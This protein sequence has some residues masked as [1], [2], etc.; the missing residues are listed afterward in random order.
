MVKIKYLQNR[1]NEVGCVHRTI[2]YFLILT[3]YQQFGFGIHAA[4]HLKYY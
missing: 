4:S 1:V 3:F 2:I